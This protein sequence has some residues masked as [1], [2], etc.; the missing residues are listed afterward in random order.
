MHQLTILLKDLH[1]KWLVGGSCGLL[2]QNVQLTTE[3]R[4]LDVY[5]DEHYV[6]QIAER[7]HE[8]VINPPHYN[9]TTIYRSNL[10]HY[11][12][13]GVRIEL[14]G[15]FRISSKGSSYRVEISEVM[16]HFSAIH[17]LDE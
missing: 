8:F 17:L 11:D 15:D 3:P 7:L 5:T 9:E 1:G 2:L 6:D 14:V 4:D 16:E 10:S 13:H 12:L